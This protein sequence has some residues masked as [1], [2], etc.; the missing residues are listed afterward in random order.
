[1]NEAMGIFVGLGAFVLF[2][3]GSYLA[4]QIARIY[5]G[6]ADLD[7]RE[8]TVKILAIDDLAKKKG[9]DIKKHLV[10]ESIYRRKSF[11]KKLEEEVINNFFR[12]DKDK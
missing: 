4:Y 2:L 12:K 8:N 10:E 6:I 7:E 11:R 1:M 5:R 9:I 3:V